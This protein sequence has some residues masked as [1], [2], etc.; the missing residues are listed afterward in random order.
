M[1]Y[2]CVLFCVHSWLYEEAARVSVCESWFGLQPP[3]I[4][5]R[6]HLPA[7]PRCVKSSLCIVL[8]NPIHTQLKFGASALCMYSTCTSS[9]LP[10]QQGTRLSILKHHSS[11]WGVHKYC[12]CGSVCANRLLKLHAELCSFDLLWR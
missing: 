10:C 7:S 1:K 11:V 5:W 3:A 2:I 12:T 9:W 6:S 4:V 8:H